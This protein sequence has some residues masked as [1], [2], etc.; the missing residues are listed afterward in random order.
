MR[1][2]FLCLLKISYPIKIRTKSFSIFS[3]K[4]LDAY[5]QEADKY[6]GRDTQEINASA[7]VLRLLREVRL[8]CNRKSYHAIDLGCGIP[9]ISFSNAMI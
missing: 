7:S 9:I 8:N 2:L 6:Y 1:P 3:C 4:G 5:H